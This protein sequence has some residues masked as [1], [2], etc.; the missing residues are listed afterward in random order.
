MLSDGSYIEVTLE[1]LNGR[2][3][4]H[5]YL[6][7]G[8]HTWTDGKENQGCV[9]EAY[10]LPD[11]LMKNLGLTEPDK[12]AFVKTHRHTIEIAPSHENANIEFST[13][14]GYFVW[15]NEKR[16]ALVTAGYVCAD[17]PVNR[18]RSTC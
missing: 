3:C 18:H 16:P 7:R 9:P 4:T 5:V 2:H 14:S 10:V 15:T 17:Q 12:S 8:D 6:G 11:G 13:C 1:V